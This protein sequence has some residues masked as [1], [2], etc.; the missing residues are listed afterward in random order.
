M[1]DTRSSVAA[2]GPKTCST[3]PVVV[4]PGGG[5]ADGHRVDRPVEQLARLGAERG[6]GL[7]ADQERHGLPV[8]GL[9]VAQRG[10]V[11]ADRDARLAGGV[12]P[13]GVGRDRGEVA[14]QRPRRSGR[15]GC[16][17]GPARACCR[18]APAASARN[19]IVLPEPV[20]ASTQVRVAPWVRRPASSSSASSWWSRSTTS[21]H[22]AAGSASARARSSPGEAAGRGS[23]VG[24]SPSDNCADLQGAD[25]PVRTSARVTG[26]EPGS[27]WAPAATG[28]SARRAARIPRPAATISPSRPTTHRVLRPRAPLASPRCAPA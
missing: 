20:G 18:R 21:G 16:A 1:A 27:W 14:R 2:T 22:A 26:R 25:A 4:A 7:V 28:S 6:V 10:L 13:L 17:G 11:G 8:H 23:V 5:E 19:M 9:L 12:G 24:C 3:W 15:P